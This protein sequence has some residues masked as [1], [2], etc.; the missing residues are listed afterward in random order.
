M[1]IQFLQ[2][3]RNFAKGEVVKTIPQGSAQMLVQRNIAKVYTPPE[4]A[5]VVGNVIAKV[6][7]SYKRKQANA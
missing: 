1:T 6:V 3:W 7:T 5:G 4:P 2:D